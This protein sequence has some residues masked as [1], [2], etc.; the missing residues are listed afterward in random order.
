MNFE[1][2]GTSLASLKPLIGMLA[3]NMGYGGMNIIAKVSLDEGLNHFVFV[4]YKEVVASM[5]MAHF[6]YF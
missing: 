1:R 5:A 3:I 2:M 4:A 6:A